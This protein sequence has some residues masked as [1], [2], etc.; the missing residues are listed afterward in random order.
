MKS[1]VL[2]DEIRVWGFEKNAIVFDDGSLG[3]GL[4]VSPVDVTCASD[5]DKNS[6]ANSIIQFLNGLPSGTDLQLVCDIRSGNNAPVSEFSRIAE[7]AVN[8]TAKELTRERAEMFLALDQEGLTPRYDFYLFV[9]RPM[10]ER[11]VQR[12]GLTLNTRRYPEI[13]EERFK[14]EVSALQRLRDDI[15]ANLRTLGI[16]ARDLTSSEV[17][18]LMYQQ[19]NPDR[20]EEQAPYD[21]EDVKNSLTFSDVL[22][23]PTGFMIGGQHHRLISLKLL[24]DTTHSCLGAA[25]QGLPFGSRLFFS[26]HVPDQTRELDALKTQR[27]VAFS[28]ARGNRSGAGDI[29]S[30]AKLQDLESL[31]EQL[32]ASGEKVFHFSC[33]V[34]LRARDE[35]A[36]EEKINQALVAI[37][38]LAGAEAMVETIASFPV[39]CELAIP[40]ARA[41]ERARKIKTSNLAD[42]LPIY[43]PW[44]GC[45]RPSVLMRTGSGALLKFDPFD[46]DFTN[47]NQL[48]SGGSGSGKSYLCNLLLMQ[49]LKENPRVFFVDIGGSYKKLCENLGGQYIPLGADLGI[50]LN[51]FDLVDPSL[52]VPPEKVKF[53]LGLVELM[54]KEEHESRLPK[55][56]RAEI[57]KAIADVFAQ[58]KRPRLS[59]LRD[60]LLKSLDQ[61]VQR[62]GKILGPWCGDTLFG[63]FLDQPTSISLNRPIVAFDLKGL[64]SY[65]DLQAVCLFIITDLVWRE[66][67]RDRS[68]KKILVFDECW[69]L[70][71]SESGI[72]FIEEV[73]RTFRKYK[74]SAIAISQDV[75]DF[76]KSKISR[77]LLSNCSI[78]WLLPQG[79]VDV[80][81]LKSTL[82]LND[83]EIEII[84]SLHQEKGKYS[85]AFLI[86]Q[87][88]RSLCIVEGTP[89][90]YWI[91]TTDP[92]D[93]A[94]VDEFTASQPELSHLDRLKRLAELY[95][96]GVAAS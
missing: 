76:A 18:L 70:L 41:R 80:D 12:P 53:L 55:L 17:A 59:H 26:I 38:T 88:R 20:K 60:L 93:L 29:E 31:I 65:P 63:K 51:P 78:K 90:E 15:M 27:R 32:I 85:Q 67:Q 49:M 6:L 68:T 57:E 3:F 87:Q 13:S 58:K 22:I 36:L 73:Y 42:L 66:V 33:N 64:E 95:P 75:D 28:L 10:S 37:R 79:Q 81:A 5:E 74:A 54:T 8:E 47:S 46:P 2:S 23:Q 52:P 92:K 7:G 45:Q 96:F 34:L 91:A 25:L 89:L 30:E 24:P 83:S 40:N 4:N 19:W 21:P 43:G 82:G 61:N 48:I 44:T 62:Y 39:F 69:K 16:I 77:A 84:K 71:K 72:V 86:A 50:S 14:R 35:D 11:L 94:K 1:D 56:E 9:R